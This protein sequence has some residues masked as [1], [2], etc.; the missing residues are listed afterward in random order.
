[1]YREGG[2]VSDRQWRDIVSALRT[3]ARRIDIEY[4]AGVAETTD[5]GGLLARA[6]RDAGA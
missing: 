6:R 4:L 1:L 5:L 2:E 3:Q